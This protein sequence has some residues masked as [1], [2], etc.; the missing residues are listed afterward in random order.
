VSPIRPPKLACLVNG[1]PVLMGDARLLDLLLGLERAGWEAL[2]SGRGGAYYSEHLTQNALMAFPFGVMTREEAID[3]MDSA[4]PWSMFE[5]HDPR[6][7]ALTAD[8]GVLA[9]RAVAQRTGEA[10]YFA[11]ISSTFVRVRGAWKLA[12]HQQTPAS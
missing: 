1:Y 9:Y 5:I 11:L 3:A 12:F 7:V 6:V 10:P 2:S 4:S 8:S